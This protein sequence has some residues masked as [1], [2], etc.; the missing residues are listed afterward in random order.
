MKNE[1]YQRGPIACGIEAT[2]IFDA[3]TSGVFCVQ[4]TYTELNH[5]I[6]IVGWGYDDEA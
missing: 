1:I 2:D 4:A 3:Y 6:S 5:A